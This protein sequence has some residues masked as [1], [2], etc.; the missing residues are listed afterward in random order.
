MVCFQSGSD[1]PQGHPFFE[2]QQVSGAPQ[3][4]QC[5]YLSSNSS[6]SNSSNSNSSNSKLTLVTGALQR[7]SVLV[8][9]LQLFQLQLFQ[10]QIFQLQTSKCPEHRIVH[11]CWY[12]SSNSLIFCWKLLPCLLLKLLKIFMKSSKSLLK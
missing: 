5:W 1:W 7:L 4:H 2:H 10:L 8:S 3:R 6:N 12:L 9:L 11:Q